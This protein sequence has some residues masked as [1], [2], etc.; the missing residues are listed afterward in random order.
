[1][2]LPRRQGLLLLVVFPQLLTLGALDA[3]GGQAAGVGRRVWLAGD[4]RGD[5][6]PLPAQVLLGEGEAGDDACRRYPRACVVWL[7]PR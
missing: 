1:M 5:G 3:G 7:A 4:G 6:R 2:L